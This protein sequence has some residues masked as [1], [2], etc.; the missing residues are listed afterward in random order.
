MADRQQAPD[1]IPLGVASRLLGVD[2]ATLRRWATAGRVESYRTPGGHRRFSRAVVERV[3]ASRTPAGA[4]AWAA[5][6]PEHVRAA[7]SRRIRGPSTPFP[8]S[9]VATLSPSTVAAYRERGRR[10]IQIMVAI[11]DK[12]D[13]GGRAGR[14]GGPD[15]AALDAAAHVEGAETARSGLPLIPALNA[16]LAARQPFI[17]ELA[18]HAGRRRLSAAET[19]RLMT[20]GADLLNRYLIAYVEG[21]EAALGAARAPAATTDLAPA[22]PPRRAA[23]GAHG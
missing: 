23:G 4:P 17:A 20:R 6:H 15:I 5:A 16:V 13:P 11:L 3:R 7:Y 21:F 8:E 14:E 19:A 18:G 10:T 22:G 12:P 1:W 2:P 9:W